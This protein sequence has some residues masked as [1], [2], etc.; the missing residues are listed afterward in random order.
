MTNY[1][2]LQQ[3]ILTWDTR[4][5]RTSLSDQNEKEEVTVKLNPDA[6]L[7]D[8]RLS[9]PE[10]GSRHSIVTV[11]NSMLVKTGAEGFEEEVVC[12]DLSQVPERKSSLTGGGL[13]VDSNKPPVKRVS[14]SN[15]HSV[16]NADSGEE[17]VHVRH[18]DSITSASTDSSEDSTSSGE[19]KMNVPHRSKMRPKLPVTTGT[20]KQI[21]EMVQSSFD[22]MTYECL[23]EEDW[24]PQVTSPVR[25]EMERRKSAPSYNTSD[26][27]SRADS[28]EMLPMSPTSPRTGSPQH[29]KVGKTLSQKASSRSH[30]RGSS[31][32]SV[33]SSDSY[34]S[35]GSYQGQGHCFSPTTS[36]S[37][38]LE[39]DTLGSPL[40][41]T[42]APQPVQKQ[43][44]P[45]AAK[46]GTGKKIRPQS[47]PASGPAEMGHR[48][49][50][51]KSSLESVE[52][53]P[54]AEVAMI[55]HP[56]PASLV[57]PPPSVSPGPPAA[58]RGGYMTTPPP[59]PPGARQTSPHLMKSSSQPCTPTL[60][61]SA[62]Q[63]SHTAH[64]QPQLYGLDSPVDC[65]PIPAASQAP[66][67]ISPPPPTSSMAGPMSPRPSVHRHSGLTATPVAPPMPPVLAAPPTPPLVPPTPRNPNTAIKT[68]KRRPSGDQRVI[69]GSQ[70]MSRS[71]GSDYPDIATS[72]P[73]IVMLSELP[74]PS[75]SRKTAQGQG[76][77]PY[78][79]NIEDINYAPLP[80]IAELNKHMHKTSQNGG[81]CPP[82]SKHPPET[83][84][85]PGDHRQQTNIPS[86]QSSSSVPSMCSS[87]PV[88]PGS[89]GGLK[90][91]PLSEMRK[92][93]PPPPPKRSE[94][95]KLSSNTRTSTADSNT[96]P[97]DPIYGNCDGMLDIN[98]LPPPPP[99]LLEGYAGDSS[100]K[101]SSGK[102][103]PP[104]PPPPKR[105]KDTQISSSAY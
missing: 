5:L 14:F 34:Q 65:F 42:I 49:T 38:S 39:G 48:R 15:T 50:S 105:S 27:Y 32:S 79:N 54:R 83:L 19:G 31:I 51:S 4:D 99:E 45:T 96:V 8:S 73:P 97:N 92:T 1:Q 47:T 33:D 12:L 62:A 26:I 78:I 93:V 104:P 40:Y 76:Q 35:Q 23:M 46:P 84:P 63:F 20:T 71:L 91:Q 11:K 81:A 36:L 70:P 25:K 57:T 98:E 37:Y 72:R 30:S 101:T 61:L 24:Q 55:T 82:G 18:R 102:G 74:L 88:I 75:T 22:N 44:P 94:T 64:S 52:E 87:Q 9:L 103:R 41:E 69:D 95:T 21:S 100:I 2:N 43:A 16:I 7:Q 13:L 67:P 58:V 90:S 28:H 6:D 89:T 29:L 77:D 10:P 59:P 80:F 3:E 86:S 56:T 85:K 68:H 53:I 60:N 66:A 17:L